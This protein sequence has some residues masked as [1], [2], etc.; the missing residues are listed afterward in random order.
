[1]SIR[2]F[3]NNWEKLL[4]L[5]QEWMI[6]FCEVNNVQPPTIKV[7]AREAW[8]F[9]HVCAYYRPE[10]ELRR[11]WGPTGINICLELCGR[12]CGELTSRNWSWPGNTTDRE[13]FGVIAHELG[14]HFDWYASS[15]EGRQVYSG[16]YG[17]S[18]MKES[19]EK[20]ISGYCPDPAEWFAEMFRVFVTNPGLLRCLRPRTYSILSKKWDWIGTD[21][22]RKALGTNVP[23]RVVTSLV[24]KG[25][26]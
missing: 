26:T 2:Y 15:P 19:G 17:V 23:H 16:D 25:A 8:H 6:H 1:M 7:V 9:S 18:V 21:S 20:P 12:P 3:P 22:W 11:E 14:H 5:G 4:R 13:P 24:N 10:T